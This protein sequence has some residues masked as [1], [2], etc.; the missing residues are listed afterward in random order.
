MLNISIKYN[1]HVILA[2]ISAVLYRAQKLGAQYA[3]DKPRL[4]GNS[5]LITCNNNLKIVHSGH[6]YKLI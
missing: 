1:L 6:K 2:P 4:K 5:C 3:C